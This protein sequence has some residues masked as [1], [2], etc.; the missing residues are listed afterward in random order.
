MQNANNSMIP[1][2]PRNWIQ[3]HLQV[4]ASMLLLE[5]D[6]G[7][8]SSY[9]AWI[10]RHFHNMHAPL[11]VPRDLKAFPTVAPHTLLHGFLRVHH[12]RDIHNGTNCWH[13]HHPC[14]YSNLLPVS[15]V[16]PAQANPQCDMAA[17][18]ES[19]CES[20][21]N[22]G[23]TL[24]SE[25]GMHQPTAMS[26]TSISSWKAYPEF[27]IF[28]WQLKNPLEKHSSKWNHLPWFCEVKKWKVSPKN[29]WSFTTYPGF[30]GCF[31]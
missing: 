7:T 10:D 29:I 13:V 31:S 18:Q 12:P 17:W 14:S 11:V 22:L 23:R 26:R 21:M 15:G 30:S 6:V 25:P 1:L 20:S 2:K 5:N 16:V 24:S 3:K 9:Q 27:L 8:S 4:V 19:T 28:R